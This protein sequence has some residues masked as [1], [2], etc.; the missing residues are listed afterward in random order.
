MYPWSLTNTLSAF[1]LLIKHLQS[2]FYLKVWFLYIHVYLLTY[3]VGTLLHFLL[4]PVDQWNSVKPVAGM[5]IISPTCWR[6]CIHVNKQI[7]DPC[8]KTLLHSANNGQK[9][10][11]IPFSTDHLHWLHV[12]FIVSLFFTVISYHFSL[13]ILQSLGTWSRF[14]VRH[15]STGL[16]TSVEM[17]LFIWLFQVSC[18]YYIYLGGPFITFCLQLALIFVLLVNKMQ[19]IFLETFPLDGHYQPITFM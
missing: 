11:T 3:F 10:Q 4:P 14:S 6:T 7:G 19:G 15:I 13:R 16:S 12:Q 18:I 1:S 8:V 9:L 5:C 17:K 2:H